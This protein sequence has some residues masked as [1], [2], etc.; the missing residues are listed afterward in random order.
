ME[1]IEKQYFIIDLI[2]MCVI[3]QNTIFPT[4]SELKFKD[5]EMELKKKSPQLSS[6]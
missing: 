1:A 4:F 6:Q 2:K 3:V 5:Y